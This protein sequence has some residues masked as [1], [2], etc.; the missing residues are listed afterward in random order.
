MMSDPESGAPLFG[1][2]ETAEPVVLVTVR[3]G[4]DHRALM[5]VRATALRVVS[6]VK[7]VRYLLCD[8]PMAAPELASLLRVE[9]WCERAE[10]RLRRVEG[11]GREALTVFDPSQGLLDY[12]L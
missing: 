1:V 8:L 2:H 9:P 11:A 10:P 5:D 7:P 6:P 3:S 12:E 4:A